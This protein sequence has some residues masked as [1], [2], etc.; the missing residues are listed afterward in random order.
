MF[1]KRMLEIKIFVPADRQ[2]DKDRRSSTLRMIF[3]ASFLK[4][5]AVRFVTRQYFWTALNDNK[6]TIYCNFGGT[7]QLE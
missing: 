7:P 3:I 6:Y 5:N 4:W 2:K 1:N